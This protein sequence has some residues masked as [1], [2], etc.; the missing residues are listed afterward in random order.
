MC[1]RDLIRSALQFIL[2]FVLGEHNQ[3]YCSSHYFVRCEYYSKILSILQ[4]SS[5]CLSKSKWMKN[6][7]IRKHRDLRAKYGKRGSMSE[8]HGSP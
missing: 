7:M 1:D 5:E 8:V 2:F 3:A 6:F 4:Y